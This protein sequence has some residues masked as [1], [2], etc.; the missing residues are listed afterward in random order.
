MGNSQIL[1]SSGNESNVINFNKQELKILYKNFLKM[2]TNN[3]GLLVSHIIFSPITKSLNR[4]IQVDYTIR[5][6]MC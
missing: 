1:E 4:S 5:I 6:N 3:N 2:D